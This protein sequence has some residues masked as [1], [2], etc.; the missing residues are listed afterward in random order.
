ML[1][2][3]VDPM[4]MCISVKIKLTFG[5]VERSLRFSF[6]LGLFDR[7]KKRKKKR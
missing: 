1:F 3:F 2:V 6:V 5:G 7:K 4:K